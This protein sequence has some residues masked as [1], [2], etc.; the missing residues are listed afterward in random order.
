M[1]VIIAGSRDIEDKE[2]VIKEF[3]KLPVEATEIVS[4]GAKGVDAIG[5]WIGETIVVPVVRFEADWKKHGR[6]AG[7]I[8]N[9]QMAEY[10]DAAIVIHNGSRGSLNM[11]ETMKKL[12]KPV[13][14]VKID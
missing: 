1:K 8:R 2:L 4:G 9:Q 11:I 5:E 14:E 7:P 6:A 13:Y 12:N 3:C 10:A